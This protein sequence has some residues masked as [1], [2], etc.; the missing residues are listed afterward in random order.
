MCARA[1]PKIDPH[2]TKIEAKIGKN[3]P[4]KC[5]NGS[6]MTKNALNWLKIGIYVVLNGSD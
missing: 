6:K 1:V 4:K 2:N 5:K 3:S